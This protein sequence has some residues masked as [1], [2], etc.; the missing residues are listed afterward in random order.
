MLLRLEILSVA[1]LTNLR[2]MA[3]NGCMDLSTTPVPRKHLPTSPAI[4]ADE[5]VALL[6]AGCEIHIV[7]QRSPLGTMFADVTVIPAPAEPRSLQQ[8][9]LAVGE[10]LAP[11]FPASTTFH[12]YYDM[13][14][15][16]EFLRKARRFLVRDHL[17]R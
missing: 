15:L 12:L 5:L 2:S 16:A 14:G 10:G 8:E 6:R 3:Y 13:D 7:P 1:L 17:P 4:L 9:S 11:S